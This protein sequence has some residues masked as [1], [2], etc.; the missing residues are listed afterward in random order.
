MTNT[1]QRKMDNKM[2]AGVCSA[3]AA[4]TGLD[5]NIIRLSVA[6]VT[7]VGATIGLGLAVPALYLLAWVLL[8]AD[9]TGI[10]PAQRWFDKPKVHETMDKV[11]DAYKK[12]L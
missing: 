11:A 7:V 5:L 4:Q 2:F 6:G 8:P 12:K 1:P 9:D 3:L 10:S